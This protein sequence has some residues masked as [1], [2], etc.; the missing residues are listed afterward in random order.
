MAAI[1]PTSD[2]GLTLGTHPETGKTGPMNEPAIAGLV[3][4]VRAWLGSADRFCLSVRA[5]RPED[6][7]FFYCKGA[8]H[9][10]ACFATADW[11]A[12]ADDRGYGDAPFLAGDAAQ[13]PPRCW[14]LCQIFWPLARYGNS[15]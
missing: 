7:G 15:G 10:Q 12:P 4:V 9:D 14:A 2:I 11:S 8:S 1:L 3:L 5:A 13:L 6:D